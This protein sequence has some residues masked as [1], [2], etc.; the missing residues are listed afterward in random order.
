MSSP[1]SGRRQEVTTIGVV[2]SVDV[3]VNYCAT[4]R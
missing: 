3:I 2:G 4:P 1:S